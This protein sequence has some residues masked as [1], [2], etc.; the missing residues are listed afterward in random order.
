MLGCGLPE[1]TQHLILREEELDG[2]EEPTPGALQSLS[3]DAV[4]VVGQIII[5]ERSLR[6]ERMPPGGCD[7][8]PALLLVDEV[9]NA[10]RDALLLGGRVVELGCGT[11]LP[12]LV[13]ALLGG[14]VLATDQPLAL[15][16]LI[17]NATISGYPQSI[18]KVVA[19]KAAGGIVVSKGKGAGQEKEPERLSWG[20]L[21]EQLDKQGDYLRFRRLS[22]TGPETG[23]VRAKQPWGQVV[24]EK[25]TERPT[26]MDASWGS[27]RSSELRW[28]GEAA[29]ELLEDGKIDL[30]L[31]SDCV[32]EPFY[33]AACMDALAETIEVLCS[34]KTQALISV[35]RR[36]D[37]GLERFLEVLSESLFVDRLSQ[38]V[39]DEVEVLL[40]VARR[41]SRAEDFHVDLNDGMRRA[42]PGTPLNVVRNLRGSQSR[43]STRGSTL[44]EG[45]LDLEASPEGAAESRASTRGS[46]A[47][48]ELLSGSR[49]STKQA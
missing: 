40:Y 20:A 45:G 31:V 3:G 32:C 18:W 33:G 14:N 22:G 8:G 28:D 49:K 42:P 12:S 16:P 48:E 10:H 39:A 36:R 11:G 9:V 13:C 15:G 44:G 27:L 19:G 43:G 35:Q 29:K 26:A 41:F 5:G 6:L 2:L 34:E 21:V 37:D 30:V 47:F 38:T 1:R 25:T 46:A 17:R 7:W 4:A 24:C 23:W